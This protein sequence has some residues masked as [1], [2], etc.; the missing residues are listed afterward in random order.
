MA[1]PDRAAAQE[2]V[3]PNLAYSGG[4]PLG[5][6]GSLLEA[7]DCSRPLLELDKTREV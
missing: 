5:L 7:V 3:D 1:G 2:A 4:D 6:D